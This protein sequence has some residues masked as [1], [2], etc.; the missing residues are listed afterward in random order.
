MI[1]LQQVLDLQAQNKIKITLERDDSEN[2]YCTIRAYDSGMQ[3]YYINDKCLRLVNFHSRN[4]H[5]IC[6]RFRQLYP[7]MA[8]GIT[9]TLILIDDKL[10]NIKNSNWDWNNEETIQLE[11]LD[12]MDGVILT[13]R[14]VPYCGGSDQV[15]RA[16]H[17]LLFSKNLYPLGMRR[18]CYKTRKYRKS[19]IQAHP[20]L[21]KDFKDM[22]CSKH[23]K[24]FVLFSG[25]Q[26]YGEFI[27]LCPRYST[28]IEIDLSRESVE[29]LNETI[30][31]LYGDNS[32]EI[33]SVK[34]EENKITEGV[35]LC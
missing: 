24:Y 14:A 25:D 26:D 30:K 23:N 28:H 2:R 3:N 5:K 20:R 15:K 31:T 16:I 17:T 4:Y 12:G 21:E 11:P 8:G 18:R 7:S 1:T 29:Y 13:K 19:E 27:G 22:L 33:S 9:Q 32:F 35:T 10:Y 6:E 34:F